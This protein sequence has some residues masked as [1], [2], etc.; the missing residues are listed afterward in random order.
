MQL[1]KFRNIHAHVRVLVKTYLWKINLQ[2][3]QQHKD[4]GNLDIPNVQI[5]NCADWHVQA[6]QHT[7]RLASPLTVMVSVA[8]LP[9]RKTFVR[10]ED[11]TRTVPETFNEF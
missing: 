3:E 6:A 10:W 2:S 9:F 1:L 7:W 11:R 5:A 4:S 8:N